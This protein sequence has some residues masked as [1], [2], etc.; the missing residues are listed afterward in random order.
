MQTDQ[1]V[2]DF[3]KSI[4]LAFNAGTLIRIKISKP[5]QKS[6]ELKEV[7]IRPVEVKGNI[8]LSFIYHYKTKDVTKNFELEEGVVHVTKL[9]GIKFKNCVLFTT[10]NDIRLSYNKKMETNIDYGKPSR[11]NDATTG[12][13]IEKKHFIKIENNQYLK[14]LKVIT[15]NNQIAQDMGAKYKQINK[16]IETLD[17]IIKNSN[18][19]KQKKVSVVDMGCGKGYLTFAVY[20]HFLNNLKLDI[21]TTGVEMKK[22]L[23]DSCNLVAKKSNFKNL[24]FVKS[25]IK[26]YELKNIDILIALH[27]CDTATDDAIYKGIC[28]NSSIIILSPCC[29]K[30]IRK[31]FN[32]E[33]E[34]NDIVKHGILKERMSEIVTDT[35]RGL[36]LEAHGY[37]T[38][39]FEFI[40]DEHTHKNLMIVGVKSKNEINNLSFEKIKK[41]KKMFGIKEFYLEGLFE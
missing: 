33:N 28:S 12:H 39:I 7:A 20:D 8:K 2:L 25:T 35:M 27:A 34:L 14:E 3:I 26:G 36:I 10:D 17:S 32:V 23:V 4:K 31:E 6:D 11:S 18:I 1:K 30:Q 40:S 13:N 9:L 41:I 16:Y 22:D 5:V 37:K 38:Q 24:K 19:S 21:Q 15:Q 29:H